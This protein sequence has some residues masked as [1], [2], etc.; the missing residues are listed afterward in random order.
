MTF[1]L[2]TVKLLTIVAES[3]LQ[4]RLLAEVRRAGASGFTLTPV[5]GEGSLH[6]RVG[7]IPGENTKIEVVANHEV[8]ERLLARLAAAYFP[9][10]AVVAWVVD[11][12]V[13]RKQKYGAGPPQFPETPASETRGMNEQ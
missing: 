7:E 1:T 4:E 3:V 12:Q 9:H 8:V 11:V 6:R 2:G 10:Y 5:D 13:V